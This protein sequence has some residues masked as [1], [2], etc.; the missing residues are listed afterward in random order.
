MFW[1][2]AGRLLSPCLALI[3]LLPIVRFRVVF[4]APVWHHLD[5]VI[6]VIVATKDNLSVK[7]GFLYL[8]ACL[9]FG[10]GIYFH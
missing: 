6:N 9:F 8:F 7:I 4:I 3:N 2:M 5:F 10:C 1:L